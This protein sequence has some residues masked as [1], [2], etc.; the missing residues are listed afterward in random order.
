MPIATIRLQT[1]GAASGAPNGSGSFR[2]SS[3]VIPGP[4]VGELKE[5]P[6]C[7]PA[8]GLG[9]FCPG[10]EGEEKKKAN[11]NE[12]K[13]KA[14]LEVIKCRAVFQASLSVSHRP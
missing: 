7:L 12:K 10:T 11:N 2:A 14:H 1:P 8:G 5:D 3:R 6:G 9:G 13:G 4:N